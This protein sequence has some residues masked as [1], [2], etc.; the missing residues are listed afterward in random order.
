[1]RTRD[2]IRQPRLLTALCEIFNEVKGGKTLDKVKTSKI[3]ARYRVSIGNKDILALFFQKWTATPTMD[4]AI[5]YDKY[6]YAYRHGLATTRDDRDAHRK[7]AEP[8][9][10]EID[11]DFEAAVQEAETQDQQPTREDLLA[12]LDEYD[13][14]TEVTAPDTATLPLMTDAEMIAALRRHGYK[15]YKEVTL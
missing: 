13:R 5:D 10:V 1:M 4:D 3:E 7:T 11:T 14:R 12:A 8:Q 2:D 9:P 15:I 6:L